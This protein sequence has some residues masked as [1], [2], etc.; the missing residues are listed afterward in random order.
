[1][2]PSNVTSSQ[3]RS[4]PYHFMKNQICQEVTK[5]LEAINC[6]PSNNSCLARSSEK[7]VFGVV[8]EWCIGTS[9]ITAE[10]QNRYTGVDDVLSTHCMTFCPIIWCWV[11]IFFNMIFVPVIYK[12]E[13]KFITVNNIDMKCSSK[14]KCEI[15][16][17]SKSFVRGW[18]FIAD[19][20]N[21][22]FLSL[23]FNVFLWNYF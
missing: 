1:M 20:L 19:V 4:T 16:H 6:C 22:R 11:F 7:D 12:G 15:L 5:L 9:C 21:D 17:Y 2:Q 14:L 8:R 10:V 23:F 18:S 3:S 13:P